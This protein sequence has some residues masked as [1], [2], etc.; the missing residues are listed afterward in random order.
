MLALKRQPEITTI[1]SQHLS[2]T[3]NSLWITTATTKQLNLLQNVL[4]LHQHLA[5][6][7]RWVTRM[8]MILLAVVPSAAEVEK[9]TTALAERMTGPIQRLNNLRQELL[10]ALTLT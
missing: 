2:T 3:T 6:T 1:Q 7:V 4:C 10:K 8:R 5:M 9:L